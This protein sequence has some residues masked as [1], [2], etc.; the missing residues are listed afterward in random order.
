M[1]AFLS[2][3]SVPEKNVAKSGDQCDSSEQP[4]AQLLR[5]LAIQGCAIT[6]RALVRS[7]SQMRPAT[8]QLLTCVLAD[9]VAVPVDASTFEKR[10]PWVEMTPSIGRYAR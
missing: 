9:L 4:T 3:R 7:N 2:R 6:F 10:K 5:K 8:H 1:C